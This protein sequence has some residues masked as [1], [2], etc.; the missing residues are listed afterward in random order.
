MVMSR[1]DRASRESTETDL[2]AGWVPARYLAALVQALERE[3]VDCDVALRQSGLQREALDRPDARLARDTQ[4]RALR[5]LARA[6]R[7][8]DLGFLLGSSINLGR[9]EVG[10]LLLNAS[11]LAQGLDKLAPYFALVTPAAR[12]RCRTEANQLVISYTLTHALPYDAAVLMLEAIVVAGHRLMLFLLQQPSLPCRIQLPWPAPP[13]VERYRTLAGASLRF[14]AG[15]ALTVEVLLPREQ[16]EVPL[17]MA[18]AAALAW[19]ERHCRERLR[20]LAQVKGLADWCRWLVYTTE[21]RQVGQ[22]EVASLLGVSPKTLARMLGR[23]GT[24]FGA[25]ARA[26]RHERA[27]ELLAGSGLGLAAIAQRL[28]Y[29][30]TANFVRAFKARSGTT[31]GQFKA[32]AT[33]ATLQG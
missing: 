28:G 24:S 9:I 20:E 1:Q 10:P 6:S 3:G 22:T 17:P 29:S 16:A 32:G 30:D 7:R 4:T 13:H 27:C 18:D 31:P 23:E 12:L 8:T 14:G 25:L 21:E 11:S 33:T 2:R 15:E 19:A 26:A 5:E